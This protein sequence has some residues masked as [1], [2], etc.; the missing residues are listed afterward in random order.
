[1]G[2]EPHDTK[3]NNRQ[4]APT[5]RETERQLKSPAPM[6]NLQQLLLQKRINHATASALT[7]LFRPIHPATA[8]SMSNTPRVAAMNQRQSF[9]RFSNSALS[10]KVLARV[11]WAMFA[12]AAATGTPRRS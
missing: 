12:A 8:V 11:S 10:S 9:C 4:D 5:C 6:K 1:M 3:N 7:V 2:F